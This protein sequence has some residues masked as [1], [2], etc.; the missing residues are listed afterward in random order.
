MPAPEWWLIALP[1]LSIVT[2]IVAGIY[3]NVKLLLEIKKLTLETER[4]RHELAER[5]RRIHQPTDEELRRF[6]SESAKYTKSLADASRDFSKFSAQV[7][8][9]AP[10]DHIGGLLHDL[11]NASR[12]GLDLA[13]RI[14]DDL[15]QMIARVDYLATVVQG[16]EPRR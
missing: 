11:I 1:A 15:C 16:R 4:L 5:D 14:H 10:A 9:M 6:L 13:S 8:Q 2:A 12:H 3:A 7:L